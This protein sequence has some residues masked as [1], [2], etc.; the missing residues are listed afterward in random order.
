MKF[1]SLLESPDSKK[2]VALTINQILAVDFTFILQRIEIGRCRLVMKNFQSRV[3]NNRAAP[4]N[5]TWNGKLIFTWLAKKDN[6]MLLINQYSKNQDPG[7]RKTLKRPKMMSKINL[8]IL[9]LKS[10]EK[11]LICRTYFVYQKTRFS[12]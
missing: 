12:S 5:Y 9:K 1:L 4:M 11:Y 8:R 2:E 3:S 7:N 10:H 6:L